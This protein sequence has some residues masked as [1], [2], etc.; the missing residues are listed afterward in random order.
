MTKQQI[1]LLISLIVNVV[2]VWIILS[3][4]TSVSNDERLSEHLTAQNAYKQN[5]I[6][7]LT[8]LLYNTERIDSASKVDTVIQIKY[9]TRYETIYKIPD[10][11]RVDS[12]L[13]V[14]KRRAM[15]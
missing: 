14:F 4:S 12:V 1:I 5:A 2:L 7:S 9:K 11:A 10:S 13:S 3:P 8:V 6:D 15:S